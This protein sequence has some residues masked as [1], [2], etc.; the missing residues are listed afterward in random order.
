MFLPKDFIAT[1]EGLVFAV[2]APGLEAQKVRAFLRYADLGHGWQKQDTEQANTLLAKHFPQYLYYSP[3][4][5]AQCHAVNVTDIQQHYQP[6]PRLQALLHHEQQNPVLQDCHELAHLLQQH[7]VELNHIGVTGSLLIGAQQASSD[8]DLIVYAVEVFQQARQVIQQLM[9]ENLLQNLALEDWQVS[10]QRR[11]CDLTFEEYLWHEQRKHNKFMLHGR[12]VDISLLSIEEQ[13][14]QQY[15]K[16]GACR[17]RCQVINAD[18]AYHYPAEYLIDLPGIAKVLCFTATYIGQAVAGEYIEISG[19]LE[20]DA[21][22]MQYIVVGS[23]REARGE[24][25][26]VIRSDA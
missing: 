21:Q 7:G 19:Q 14:P 2:V 9:A 10:Y 17:I 1:A 6:R 18:R 3:Q 11:A 4:L 8:I 23:N 26:K 25:I 22:G 24:Y 5:D 15:Q 12:K 16:Q 13:Q 20:T